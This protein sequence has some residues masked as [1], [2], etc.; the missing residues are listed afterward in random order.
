MV[1]CHKLAETIEETVI[2]VR[3]AASVFVARLSGLHLNARRLSRRLAA[4]YDPR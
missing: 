3:G 4:I 2:N 1:R